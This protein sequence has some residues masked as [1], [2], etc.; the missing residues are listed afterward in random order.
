MQDELKIACEEV[1]HMRER[2]A[3]AEADRARELELNVLR[4][5]TKVDGQIC[6]SMRVLR[7]RH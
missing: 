3:R 6:P 1:F 5:G 2:L 7:W 4:I